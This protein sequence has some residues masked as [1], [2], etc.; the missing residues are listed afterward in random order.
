M[1][2]N[3][4]RAT[5]GF[6]ATFGLTAGYGHNNHTV[7]T[8]D[9]FAE[10]WKAI[11]EA[12]FK[13]SQ[14]LVGCVIHESRTVYPVSFGCPKGGEKT[15]TVSGHYNPKFINNAMPLS[16][17]KDKTTRICNAVRKMLSQSTVSLT[18]HEVADFVYL[19][20]EDNTNG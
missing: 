5:L 15:I 2:L 8:L 3:V 11:M 18:F 7:I 19:T 20:D 4:N 10:V 14:I 9:A 16:I 17:Y 12:V 6:T 1:E 13:D